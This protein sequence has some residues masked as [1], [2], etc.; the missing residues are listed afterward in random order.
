MQGFTAG[1]TREQLAVPIRIAA[2]ACRIPLQVDRT[3]AQAGT[4]QF[5]LRGV[6]HAEEIVCGQSLW[7]AVAAFDL[8]HQRRNQNLWITP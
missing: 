8:Q 6:V 3:R 2:L 7:L 4:R 1:I 5:D